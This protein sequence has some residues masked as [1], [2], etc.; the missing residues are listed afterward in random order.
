M[1]TKDGD[2]E[3][4]LRSLMGIHLLIVTKACSTEESEPFLAIEERLFATGVESDSGSGAKILN[5]LYLFLSPRGQVMLMSKV[6]QQNLGITLSNSNTFFSCTLRISRYQNISC[7]MFKFKGIKWLSSEQIK[8]EGLL[9]FYGQISDTKF[10]KLKMKIKHTP[11]RCL[12][13]LHLKITQLL[14]YK[15]YNII[16][17]YSTKLTEVE[18]ESIMTD[19]TDHIKL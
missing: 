8:V 18:P 7:N 12:A 14:F 6:S 16:K 17:A 10:V 1:T 19:A 15:A 3:D 5:E 11:S 2:V 9:N 4:L 13:F